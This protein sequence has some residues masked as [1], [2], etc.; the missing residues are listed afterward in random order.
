MPGI[1][2]T[3]LRD[4]KILKALIADM[5]LPDIKIPRYPRKTTTI[6]NYNELIL[7]K[8]YEVPGIS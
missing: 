4:L 6:S 3:D 2:F 1:K 8:D 7:N 5:F